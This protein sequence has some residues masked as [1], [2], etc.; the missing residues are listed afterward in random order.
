MFIIIP[1]LVFLKWRYAYLCVPVT[2]VQSLSSVDSKCT[3][4]DLQNQTQSTMD[5]KMIKI[6]FR[7]HCLYI[8]LAVIHLRL[9][10]LSRYVPFHPLQRNSRKYN[11]FHFCGRCTFS[12]IFLYYNPTVSMCCLVSLPGYI[13][14]LVKIWQTTLEDCRRLLEFSDIVLTQYPKSDCKRHVIYDFNITSKCNN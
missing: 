3:P 5:E 4:Y 11:I 9:I 13:C 2:F 12:D 6:I 14:R 10:N 1:I 7:A 8:F